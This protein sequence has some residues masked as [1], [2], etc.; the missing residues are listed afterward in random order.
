[1][2]EVQKRVY[3]LKARVGVR[4]RVHSLL[5]AASLKTVIASGSAIQFASTRGRHKIVLA[6]F[7]ISFDVSIAFFRSFKLGQGISS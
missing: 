2:T 4:L 7:G 5:A 3:D 1:M 6:P